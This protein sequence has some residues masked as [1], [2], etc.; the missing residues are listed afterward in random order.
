LLQNKGNNQI[1]GW[2]CQ[3]NPGYG[4]TIIVGNIR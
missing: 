2:Y 3:L 1:K 4:N